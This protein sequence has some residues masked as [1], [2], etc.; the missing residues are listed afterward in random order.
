M[1]K[2]VLFVDQDETLVHTVTGKVPVGFTEVCLDWNGQPIVLATKARPSAHQ[3]LK[4]AALFAD[5]VHI[6]TSGCSMPQSRLLEALGLRSLVGT[7]FGR[8]NIQTL[9][10]PELWVLV[11]D[12]NTFTSGVETKMTWLGC[13][14]HKLKDGRNGDNLSDEGPLWNALMATHYVQCGRYCG[15]EDSSLTDQLPVIAQ[16]FKLQTKALTELSATVQLKEKE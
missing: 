7:V 11:D 16:R 8:D 15:K 4:D 14:V 12:L 13:Q 9:V 2:K 5:E 6:L 3:F 1:T 10:R